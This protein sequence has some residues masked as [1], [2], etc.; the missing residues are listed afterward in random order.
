MKRIFLGIFMLVM[1]C[2]SYASV[3]KSGPWSFQDPFAQLSLQGNEQILHF[4]GSQQLDELTQK[5]PNGS[6]T[7]VSR[8]PLIRDGRFHLSHYDYAQIQG[9]AFD[10]I[11]VEEALTKHVKQQS[12]LNQFNTSLKPQGHLLL[13]LPDYKRG[14]VARALTQTWI[15]LQDFVMS[16]PRY[17]SY[18]SKQYQRMLEKS[19]LRVSFESWRV[20]VREFESR[21]SLIDWL[22]H[23]WVYCQDM[24]PRDRTLF[25]TVFVDNYIQI[26]NQA[27]TRPILWEQAFMNIEA[28]KV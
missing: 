25:V 18:S 14:V 3:F 12:L 1:A 26:S 22:N 11:L 9:N 16:S 2:T 10:H 8:I 17:L 23:N 21:E 24:T 4:G 13:R 19:G 20:D 6:V 15:D 7:T 28:I 27:A 5:L